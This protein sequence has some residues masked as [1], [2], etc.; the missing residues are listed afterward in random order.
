ML[1]NAKKKDKNSKNEVIPAVALHTDCH[2]AKK[3]SLFIFMNARRNFKSKRKRIIFCWVIS[4][5]SRWRG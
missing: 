5:L 1:L 2:P 4:N 3:F